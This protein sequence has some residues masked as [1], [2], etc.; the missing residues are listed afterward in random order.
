M[1]Q[2]LGRRR[3]SQDMCAFGWAH[4]TSPL[5]RASHRGGYTIASREWPIGGNV[6]NED[7]VA[8][9]D[10]SPA[11]EV[12]QDRVSNVLR[13][14]QTNLVA[15]LPGDSQCTGLPLYIRDAKSRDVA[16]SEPE[17]CQKHDDCSITPACRC[18]AVTRGYQAVDLLRRQIPWQSGLAPGGKCWHSL[19]EIGLTQAW[20]LRYRKNARKPVVSFSAVPAPHVLV[21][22]RK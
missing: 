7:M 4:D 6:S 20:A 2:H 9:A 19:V 1:T 8:I 18:T 15:T 5:H 10:G 12:V 14:R 22:C 11:R 17:P 21:R 13:E 16:G 3:V